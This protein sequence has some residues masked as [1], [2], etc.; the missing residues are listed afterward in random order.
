L[1]IDLAH[2]GFMMVWGV[3]ALIFMIFKL[4]WIEPRQGLN[5]VGG[6]GYEMPISSGP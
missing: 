1:F 5:N 4:R 3:A 2:L 6:R